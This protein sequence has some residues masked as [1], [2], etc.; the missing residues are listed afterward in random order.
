MAQINGGGRGNGG[1]LIDGF[2]VFFMDNFESKINPIFNTLSLLYLL[3]SQTGLIIMTKD[4][5]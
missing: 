5:P 2:G 1:R 4:S 3:S